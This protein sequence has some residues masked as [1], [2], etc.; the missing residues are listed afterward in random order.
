MPKEVFPA[1]LDHLYSM[2]GF[3]RSHGL[4]QGI[5]LET[6]E[7]VILAAEEAL[8]NIIHYS[9]PNRKGTVEIDCHETQERQGI[10]IQLIDNGIPFNPITECR[11]KKGTKPPLPS[12]ENGS[13]KG[14]YGIYIFMG[15]MDHVEYQRLKNGNLLSLTKYF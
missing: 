12:L 13:K 10:I 7:K 1:D 3:I 6:L 11:I 8:V 4:T 9:Y 14:G 5:H 2:L 15:I